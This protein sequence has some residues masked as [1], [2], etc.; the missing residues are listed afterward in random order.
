MP[1]IEAVTHFPASSTTPQVCFIFVCPRIGTDVCSLLPQIA[2]TFLD[3]SVIV[4]T[5]SR[6]E[7]VGFAHADWAATP[8]GARHAIAAPATA[9][10]K[11]TLDRTVLVPACPIVT[12][13]L[14]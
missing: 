11:L 2:T 5:V 8:A 4:S 13:G 6:F 1:E 9:P 7:D 10:R 3:P 14:F 12:L